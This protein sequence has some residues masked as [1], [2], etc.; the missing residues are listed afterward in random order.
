VQNAD[1]QRSFLGAVVRLQAL[2]SSKAR[3][4]SPVENSLQP[5]ETS[6]ADQSHHDKIS[7]HD[8]YGHKLDYVVELDTAVPPTVERIDL[9]HEN[10]NLVAAGRV[11]SWE[12]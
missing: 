2:F 9:V 6:V 7:L 8:P 1:G 4:V 11:R 12:V 5:A 3:D 10:S